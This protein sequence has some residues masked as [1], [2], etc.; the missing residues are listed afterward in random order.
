MKNDKWEDDLHLET[1]LWIRIH[2]LLQ[3]VMVNVNLRIWCSYDHVNSWH[4]HDLAEVIIADFVM[5]IPIKHVLYNLE[6]TI[7]SALIKAE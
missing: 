5:I 1:I 2:D 4:Y 7:D 3:L 6:V